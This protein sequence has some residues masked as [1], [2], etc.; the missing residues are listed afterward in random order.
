MKKTLFSIC[1]AIIAAITINA[2][3][4]SGIKYQA[5]ARNV[6]GAVLANQ[7]V[8]LE[9]IIDKGQSPAEEVF[10]ET[11]IE[12][13]NE[14][15]LVNLVIGSK[16]PS[17]LAAINWSDGEY[18]ISVKLNGDGMG[19]SKILS[20]P[21]ALYAKTAENYTETD[22]AISSKF[23]LSGASSGDILQYNASQGKWVRTTMPEGK[24]LTEVDPIFKGSAANGITSTLITNWNA[25]YSYGAHAGKYRPIAWVP[26][27]TDI[28]SKPIT[29]SGFGITDGVTLATAQTI[30][31]T[32]TFSKSSGYAIV[33]D[34]I[35]INPSKSMVFGK[36]GEGNNRLAITHASGTYN[37]AYIDYKESLHFRADKNWLSALTLYGDGTVGVGFYT[38]YDPGPNFYKTKVNGEIYMFAVNGKIICEGVTQIADVPNADYVFEADYD[39]K[40]LAD[41]EAFVRENKHL[42]DIPSAEQFKKDGYRIGEMDE[43]LLRKVEELTLYLIQQNKRLEALE[44]E[45]SALKGN[46]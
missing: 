4:P 22:P 36:S 26:A 40:P 6:D 5:V 38:T 46:N 30:S 7:K 9:I 42:R 15:G 34:N 8:T 29:L 37:H 35:N 14:F 1:V 11:H 2:Q 28:T 31:G 16:N 23:S 33:V 19:T 24:T 21:Y 13:T 39:L 20:V 10:T 44:A 43:M 12:T 27:W 32:K 25:A 45:N 17:G 18:Y 3:V 41:V